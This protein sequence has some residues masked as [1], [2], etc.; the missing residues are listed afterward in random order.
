MFTNYINSAEKDIKSANLIFLNDFKIGY[1]DV[2]WHT[3]A[4]TS[5][6]LTCLWIWYFDVDGKLSVNSLPENIHTGWKTF[7]R[8]MPILKCVALV[9]EM[10]MIK[11][12]L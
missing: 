11:E 5:V 7:D 6:L 1:I 2:S 8:Y 9:L 10:I 3:A 4:F 12:A